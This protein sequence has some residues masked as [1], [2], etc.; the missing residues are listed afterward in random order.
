VRNVYLFYPSSN[1]TEAID[2]EVTT[3]VYDDLSKNKHLLKFVSRNGYQVWKRM[4]DLPPSSSNETDIMSSS[5]TQQLKHIKLE[6]KDRKKPT[7]K[8]KPDVQMI[9]S[10]DGI[11]EHKVNT[12]EIFKDFIDMSEETSNKIE[13]MHESEQNQVEFF[14]M[15]NTQVHQRNKYKSSLNKRKSINNNTQKPRKFFDFTN[16]FGRVVIQGFNGIIRGISSLFGF[17]QNYNRRKSPP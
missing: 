9:E 1:S 14:G 3:A 6:K 11:I 17:N 12:P 5:S 4:L 16:K 15:P 2:S 8:Y 13:P 10:E 7:Q